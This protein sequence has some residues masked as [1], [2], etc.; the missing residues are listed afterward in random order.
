MASIERFLIENCPRH[1]TYWDIAASP[2][3]YIY[4]GACMEHTPEGIAELV[5]FNQKTKKLRSITNMA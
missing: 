5:Q 1:D 3:N 4:I 2:D